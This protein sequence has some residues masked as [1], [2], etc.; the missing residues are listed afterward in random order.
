MLNQM[1]VKLA[2]TTHMA[3]C[4][5]ASAQMVDQ[6][7]IEILY[8]RPRFCIIECTI[9]T[10][11]SP[12]T[13]ISPAQHD[14]IRLRK[15]HPHDAIPTTNQKVGSSNLS[16]RATSTVLIRRQAPLTFAR[17]DEAS[18]RLTTGANNPFGDRSLGH[19]PCGQVPRAWSS[20]RE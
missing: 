17:G 7:F 14:P 10:H 2:E 19:Q 20:M 13:M 5:A 15:H 16:G 3:I 1:T 9:S 12:D 11:S 18:T 6:M 4:R 8:T